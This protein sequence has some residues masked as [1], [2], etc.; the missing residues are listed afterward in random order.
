MIKSIKGISVLICPNHEQYIKQ[1]DALR[2]ENVVFFNVLTKY[3]LNY[4]TYFKDKKIDKRKGFYKILSKIFYRFVPDV[5]VTKVLETSSESANKTFMCIKDIVVD[6]NKKYVIG[7]FGF[8][9]FTIENEI[10]KYFATEK[11]GYNI[12]IIG[13]DNSL[14]QNKFYE[15][16]T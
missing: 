1:L 15:I 12:L 13:I 10:L 8:D 5:K 9:S 11:K 6:P 16:I 2:S 14:K 7:L 4:H 3:S